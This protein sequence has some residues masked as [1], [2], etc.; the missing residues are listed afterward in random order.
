MDSIHS[1]IRSLARS[2]GRAY[3]QN[4][5]A[6]NGWTRTS[7]KHKGYRK[8]NLLGVRMDY[9]MPCYSGAETSDER[10]VAGN[11][12]LT[13]ET[14]SAPAHCCNVRPGPQVQVNQILTPIAHVQMKSDT[15]SFSCVKWSCDLFLV[16][17]SPSGFA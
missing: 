16:S 9:A 10:C 3:L 12:D 4:H 13:T 1:N 8:A 14:L 17:V 6:A 11:Y 2:S 5:R 15:C 7:K